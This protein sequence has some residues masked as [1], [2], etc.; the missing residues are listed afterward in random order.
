M[1]NNVD[2]NRNTDWNWGGTGSSGN[3]KS[4]E[5]RGKAPFSEPETR[6]V[7]DVA[8]ENGVDAYMSMHTAYGTEAAVENGVDASMHTGAR[9]IFVPFSD[10]A[11]KQSR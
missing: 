5:Y 8:V 1:A 6:F 4:E 10:T 2:L 9:F 7:R 11:S 3:I